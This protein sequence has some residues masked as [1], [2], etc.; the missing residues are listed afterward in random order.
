MST[1]SSGSSCAAFRV[2][3][4]SWLDSDLTAAESAVMRAHADA[5]TSCARYDAEVRVGMLLARHLTPVTVSPGFKARLAERLKIERFM[6]EGPRRGP[7][8]KGGSSGGASGG[9]TGRMIA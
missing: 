6:A 8:P 9:D 2:Q 5:C 7:S 4:L 1:A 3:H